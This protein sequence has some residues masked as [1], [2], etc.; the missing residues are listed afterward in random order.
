VRFAHRCCP[1]SVASFLK[2]IS[3][4]RCAKR[5]LRLLN[6][7]RAGMVR[8]PR[9][10]AWSSYRANAEGKTDELVS[11]HELY[12]RLAS[13]EGER[14]IAYRSLVKPPMNATLL[15]EIR[16]CTNKG[17]ALGGRFQEKIERLAECRTRPLP[18]GRPKRGDEK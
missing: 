1:D 17:W 10:Y 5:T 8:H 16:D 4:N 11:P 13:D 3:P 6:P 18:N 15:G 9:D 2:F 12:R 14:R 7:V